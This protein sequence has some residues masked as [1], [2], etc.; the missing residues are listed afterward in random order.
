M[1]IDHFDSIFSEPVEAARKIHR[2]ANDQRADAELAHQSAAIPAG[3]QRG[4]HDFVAICAL[5]SRLAKCVG[6]EFAILPKPYEL[7]ELSRALG[8][9]LEATARRAANAEAEAEV[10]GAAAS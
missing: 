7:P 8:A 10:Q 4:H 1:Q 2:F 9:V 6:Q 5:P 3:R